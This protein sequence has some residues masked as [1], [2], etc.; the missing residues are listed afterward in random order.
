MQVT[1]ALGH[2]GRARRI[3]PECRLVGVGRRSRKR[4]AFARDLVGKLPVAMR[5][6]AGDHDMFEI[7]HAADDVLY[8]RQQRL[9]DEQDAGAAIGQ[10][11][12]ILVGGQKR[13]QRYRHHA[14][15]DRAQ[16]HDRE[17][18]RVEHHHRHPL[19]AADA[20]PAQQI[21]EPPRLLLQFAIGE[22]CDGIVE[23]DLVAAAFVDV[24]VK[25]PGHRIVGRAHAPLLMPQRATTPL[26]HFENYNS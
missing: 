14:G 25:Q 12:G 4:V 11:I 18:D 15:T 13:I 23:H 21:A 3:E 9:G 16:E 6:L 22:F 1:H 7:G 24:A 8:D 19:L 26:S 2:A 20:E 17:I 5:I 10:H